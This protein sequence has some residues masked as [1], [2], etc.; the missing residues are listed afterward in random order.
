MSGG[1][2][3]FNEFRALSGVK[4]IMS[5][6]GWAFSTEPATAPIFR[7]GV[8]N[9]QRQ[10]FADNVAAVSLATWLFTKLTYANMSDC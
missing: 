5:F 7:D 10:I 9:G 4:K 6:G 1:L 3:L 2:D 8:S